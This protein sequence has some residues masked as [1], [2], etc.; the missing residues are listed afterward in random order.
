MRVKQADFK[1]AISLVEAAKKDLNFTLKLNVSADSA[2][3]IVRNV[4][5]CF[6]MLGEALLLSEGKFVTDHREMILKLV[7]L[8]VK[9]PRPLGALENLRLM[10][11]RINYYGYRATVREAKYAL[12]LA[13]CCFEPLW[14]YVY[15]FLNGKVR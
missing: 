7:V 9:T 3:T 2:S 8:P 10:R 13:R 14:N 4:Y 6:R 5:E 11:H 12:S 15:N 1:R